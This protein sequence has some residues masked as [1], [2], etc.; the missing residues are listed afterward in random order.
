MAFQHLVIDGKIGD[1]FEE[2]EGVL[3]VH[4][5][6][7]V[8]DW[9][10]VIAK[11][12]KGRYPRAFE[13]YESHCSDKEPDEL[14]GTSLLIQPVDFEEATNDAT[15]TSAPKKRP[16]RAKKKP[17]RHFIGCL[18]TSRRFGKAKDGPDQVLSA[19]ITAMKSLLQQI[20]DHNTTA[21]AERKIH[22][23]SMCEINSNAFKV[24]WQDTLRAL[25]SID[26]KQHTI[27]K[28]KVAHYKPK[29]RKKKTDELV[30]V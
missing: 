2:E 16:A 24:P 21:G 23:L 30:E 7:C 25:T 20:D 3:L 22:S 8:G 11:K 14:V 12:F 28:V 19:T 10:P 27:K 17:K 6:N 18:F 26:V 5:C 1:L 13:A 4:A 9:G 29:S 15:L